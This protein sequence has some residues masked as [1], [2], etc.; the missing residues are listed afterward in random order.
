MLVVERT[1]DMYRTGHLAPSPIPSP[2][3]LGTG[4]ECIC[5]ATGEA[6]PMLADALTN[7]CLELPFPRLLIA[8][9]LMQGGEQRAPLIQI[10]VSCLPSDIAGWKD[11]YIVMATRLFCW[12]QHKL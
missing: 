1:T 9:W 12:A 10:Q 3:Q 7:A 6:T 5:K 4:L 11:T 2:K 8:M